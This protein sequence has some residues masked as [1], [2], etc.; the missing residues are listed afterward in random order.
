MKIIYILSLLVLFSGCH[1]RGVE[2]LL[3]NGGDTEAETKA[4]YPWL[5]SQNPYTPEFCA[6][7]PSVCHD[8]NIPGY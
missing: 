6:H 4:K 1:S 8:K 7:Y 5:S 3:G 2:R